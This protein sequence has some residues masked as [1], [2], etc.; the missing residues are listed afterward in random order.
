MS[1]ARRQDL[2]EQ[3]QEWIRD[4]PEAYSRFVELAL[5]KASRREKFSIHAL[6]EVIR[7]DGSIRFNKHDFAIPNNCRRYIGLRILA[8]HPH[9]APYMTTK[10]KDDDADDTPTVS[11]TDAPSP[12]PPPPEPAAVFSSPATLADD[13]FDTIFGTV[14]EVR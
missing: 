12:A 13:D 3:A 2:N 10:R 7:W 11:R 14:F 6:T 4:N 9:V 8:E 5:D 1:T